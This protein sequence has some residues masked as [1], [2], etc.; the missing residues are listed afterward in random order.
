VGSFVHTVA[1]RFT[2]YAIPGHPI[3]VEYI[4]IHYLFISKAKFTVAVS[5]DC[6]VFLL[7]SIGG[8]HGS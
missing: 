4:E 1:S 5:T 7:S 3:H 8:E 2:E 6:I